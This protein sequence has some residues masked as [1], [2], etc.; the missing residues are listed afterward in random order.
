M[1]KSA[2]G[3]IWRQ[4]S[5]SE[6]ATPEL[7]GDAQVAAVTSTHKQSVQITEHVTQTTVIRENPCKRSL[8]S[9]GEINESRLRWSI[10]SNN[11]KTTSKFQQLLLIIKMLFSGPR[12]SQ[13]CP[14]CFIQLW[15]SSILPYLLCPR[16][17]G[18]NVTIVT[19]QSVRLSEPTL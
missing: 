18:H 9:L 16:H 11:I 8:H 1:S 7:D 4:T 15:T 2:L 17:R 12:N 14:H 6:G 3:W 19:P 10:I 13:N 5:S